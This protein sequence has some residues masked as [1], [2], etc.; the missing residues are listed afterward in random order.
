MR[1][2][3]INRVASMTGNGRLNNHTYPRK[4]RRFVF[5][6]MDPLMNMRLPHLHEIESKE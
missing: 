1:K 4:M 2:P 5:Q 6:S 3:L